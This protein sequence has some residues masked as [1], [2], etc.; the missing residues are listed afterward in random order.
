MSHEIRTPL[1]GIIAVV[2]MLRG[3]ADAGERA[4]LMKIL[5]GS[6]QL[7][8]STVNDILDFSKIEQGFLSVETLDFGVTQ[9]A[10]EI[11]QLY[12]ASAKENR[13]KLSLR[14]EMVNVFRKGDPV[15]LRQI[16]NNLTSN[17]IKFTSD[18]EV[19]IAIKELPDDLVRLD[20]CDTGIGMA[21]DQVQRAFNAFEQADDS[22]TR[23]FGGT[24][25][26]LT[27]VSRVVQAMHG[28]ISIKSTPGL[29]TTVTVTL[30]MPIAPAPE[31]DLRAD[32]P[33]NRQAF[34]SPDL[35]VPASGEA[36]AAVD[37]SS[38]PSSPGKLGE[39]GPIRALAVDDNAA[40]RM[41]I[42]KMLERLDVDAVIA[43]GGA[44]AVGMIGQ[45]PFD[46]ILLDIMMP[47]MDG[48]ETL[49]AIRLKQE[50]LGLD[51][52]P[53]IAVTANSYA[54]QIEEYLA[55]GFTAHVP[56][57]IRLDTLRKTI[58]EHTDGR[59]SRAA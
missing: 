38:S 6:G 30:P 12:A 14:C 34:Q 1:N 29:G 43:S 28:E 16:L 10:D 53:A 58:A 47:D 18:G 13:N 44:Q 59:M 25:L 46:V 19:T 8:E 57:P 9:L 5:D 45:Q 56:K 22:T 33:D 3:E 15:R 20:V 32:I 27:I 4:R 36:A 41:I 7:L 54:H 50:S 52:V 40:N 42:E 24:G 49:R 21:E 48:I 35:H 51:Q 17:A 37:G 31:A 39:D 2:D 11:V 55:A 26:G 23:R